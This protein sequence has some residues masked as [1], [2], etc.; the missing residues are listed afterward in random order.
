MHDGPGIRTTVFLK[1]CPLACEWCHNPEGIHFPP[2][3][4]W[5]PNR[6]IRCGACVQACPQHALVLEEDGIIRSTADCQLCGAC[7]G[8]C[9]AAAVEQAGETYTVAKLLA[10]LLRDQIHF[11]QSGGGVTFSGGEPLAQHQFLQE[12]LTQLKQNGVHTVVDTSFFASWEKIA[13]VAA[14]TDLFLVDLKLMDSQKHRQ[15]TGVQNQRIL[16]NLLQL[17]RL[18]IPFQVRIPL[19]PQ[20]NDDHQNL[21]DSA[22][23]LKRLNNLQ[24]IDLLP[25]HNIAQD[26]YRRLG[27]EYALFQ[28]VVQTDEAIQEIEAFFKNYGFQVKIGG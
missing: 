13:A 27:K 12:I 5:Y 16:E 1:G 23:F 11:D 2:E 10:L 15:Y 20:I 7:A 26:K 17:D 25:Y 4:L 14:S 18:G 9:P 28:T 3:L 8:V 21:I 24:R 19:I 22:L 6:C